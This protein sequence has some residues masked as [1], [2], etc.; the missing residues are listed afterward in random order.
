[1]PTSTYPYFSEGFEY[2]IISKGITRIGISANYITQD[3]AADFGTGTTGI[4][5]NTRN[6]L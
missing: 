4:I 5:Q 6:A 1:M 2:L 3:D